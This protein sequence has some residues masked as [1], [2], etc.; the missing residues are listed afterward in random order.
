[1]KQYFRFTPWLVFTTT[2]LLSCQPKNTEDN[3][4]AVAAAAAATINTVIGKTLQVNGLTNFA[5]N[6]FSLELTSLWKNAP[7]LQVS[8]F[9]ESIK[10][11][12]EEVGTVVDEQN[13]RDLKLNLKSHFEYMQ[14]LTRDQN[15]GI[16]LTKEALLLLSTFENDVYQTVTLFEG[17]P[18][19]GVQAKMLGRALLIRIQSQK[20][21]WARK[22]GRTPDS[23]VRAYTDQMQEILDEDKET[24]QKYIADQMGKH[25]YWDEKSEKIRPGSA[26]KEKWTLTLCFEYGDDEKTCSSLKVSCIARYPGIVISNCGGK[27]LMES[28]QAKQ[29]YINTVTPWYMNVVF[30]DFEKT[31]TAIREARE[32]LIGQSELDEVVENTQTEEEELQ[33][34]QGD[35]MI[36]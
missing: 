35:L 20:I 1:M 24:L 31:Q 8:L 17:Q 2:L 23:N 3:D 13:L 18:F 10:K 30:G 26:R 27:Q 5:N 33:H 14:Q 36:R 15:E 32:V 19:S 21:I 25:A 12:G 4:L 28:D 22:L 16:L 9:E 11:I 29:A 7:G 6:F 34:E